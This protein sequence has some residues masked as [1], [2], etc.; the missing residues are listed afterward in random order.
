MYPLKEY[1]LL[2]KSCQIIGKTK[3]KIVHSYN[4]EKHKPL[5]CSQQYS[6]SPCFTTLVPQKKTHA[7]STPVQAFVSQSSCVGHGSPHGPGDLGFR[8][9]LQSPQPLGQPPKTHIFGLLLL[10]S[11]ISEHTQQRVFKQ[12]NKIP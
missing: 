1:L 8:T 5:A 7:P 10:R 9:V 3:D 4:R 6:R 11:V 2:N 12:Q